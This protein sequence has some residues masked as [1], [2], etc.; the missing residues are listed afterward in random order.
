VRQ[1]FR[2]QPNGAFQPLDPVN[3]ARAFIFDAMAVLY[4]PQTIQAIPIRKVHFHNNQADRK[5]KEPG[6]RL[7][8]ELVAKPNKGRFQVIANWRWMMNAR[9]YSMGKE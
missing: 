1:F 7:D 9:A 8:D 2:R 4:H 3:S 5:C 6:D